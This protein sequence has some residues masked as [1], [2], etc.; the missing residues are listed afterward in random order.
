MTWVKVCGLM[1]PED[2]AVAAEAGA[3]AVG[4]VS[5]PGSPRYLSLD[6]IA[7]LA[8]D[9]AV[10]TVILT[11]DL[12]VS[13]ALTAVEATGVTGIQPYGPHSGAVVRTAMAEG[14]FVLDPVPAGVTA[15]PDRGGIPLLDTPDEAVYG[16]TGRS[17]DW[18]LAAQ[19]DGDF[20]LAGGL[21]P[22]NVTDAIQRVHPWG[23]D[24]SSALEASPGVKDP[25]KVID[26]VRKAKLS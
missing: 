8:D 15:L 12:G 3:D 13:A 25:G 16:G 11:V 18:E 19:L 21:G 7:E 1:T 24:A 26:F 2:V 4:F 5:H 9:V 22:H 20:V 14:L 23:V 10:T 17:F 6:A